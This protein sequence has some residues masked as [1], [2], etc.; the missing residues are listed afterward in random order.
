WTV[1]PGSVP[2]NARRLAGCAARAPATTKLPP[3]LPPATRTT[4]TPFP[5]VER[6]RDV[7]ISSC[8]SGFGADVGR[9]GWFLGAHHGRGRLGPLQAGRPGRCG[10]RPDQGGHEGG[11]GVVRGHRCRDIPAVVAVPAA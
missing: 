6:G 8:R 7:D 5:T 3:V 10:G 4:M 9:E 1:P 2:P 11:P